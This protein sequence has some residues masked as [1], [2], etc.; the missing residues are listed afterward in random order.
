M[1]MHWLA[2]RA[3]VGLLGRRDLYISN[4]PEI[5]LQS[6]YTVVWMAFKKIIYIATAPFK[7][8]RDGP[9][10]LEKWNAE[11]V[12]AIVQSENTD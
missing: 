3:N 2:N 5:R 12:R 7:H 1:P 11:L 10:D 8:T 9:R 6:A 4:I